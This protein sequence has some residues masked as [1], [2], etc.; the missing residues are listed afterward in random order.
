VYLPNAGPMM[1]VLWDALELRVQS[2]DRIVNTCHVKQI[3]W[4]TCEHVVQQAKE[5]EE[6]CFH[7]M[8]DLRHTYPYD[9]KENHE[10]N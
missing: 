4:I 10:S 8:E 9:Y 6:G 1:T 3:V 7:C 5:L 2:L